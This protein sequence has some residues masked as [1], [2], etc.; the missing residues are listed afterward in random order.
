MLISLDWIKNYLPEL[1]KSAEEIEEALTLIGFEVEGIERRGLVPLQH[2]VVGE[3]L[4]KAQH[5]NADRLS[6]CKVNVGTGTPAQIVCG[7][8]NFKVGDRVPVALPGAELPGGFVIKKTK[9]RDVDSEGMM[10]SARELGMGEDH[11]GLLILEQRPEIGTPVN[12]VFPEADTVFDVEVTPNRPDCLSHVGMARELA[13]FFGLERVR[14]VIRTAEASLSVSEGE[15]LVDAVEIEDAATC[16]YY[17]AYSIRGV[18]IA[19][20]PDWLK[21]RLETIGLRPIN[22]VV[23]VTNFVLHEMGQ[24]LHAFDAGKIRGRRIIVRAAREGEKITTL[25][26]KA[27][28][29]QPQHCVIADAERAMVIAGVMGSVDAE[30]D[31]ATTDVVLEAAWF[32]AP[33]IRKTSRGLI[34]STDSSYRF[35]RGIDPTGVDVAA[36]RAVDLILELAGGTLCKRVFHE[37]SCAIEPT[38]INVSPDFIRERCGFGPDDAGVKRCLEALELEVSEQGSGSWQAKVPAFRQDL[39]RPIDLVEEFLRIHGTVKIPECAVEN[40]AMLRSHAREYTF[41]RE[42]TAYFRSRGFSEVY[43]YTLVSADSLKRPGDADDP[44]PSLRLHNPISADGTHL[45]PSLIPGMV[46]V[47]RN[48]RSDGDASGCYFEW[49]RVY[50]EVGG[51]LVEC[52]GVGLAVLDQPDRKNW[53]ARQG[54]D[55][56]TVK[57][58]VADVLRLAGVTLPDAQFRLLNGCV[59]GQNGHFAVGGDLRK[60]PCRVELGMLDLKY[61]Q[62]ADINGRVYAASIAILPQILEKAPKAVRY[63]SFSHFPPSYKDLALVV[64]AATSAAE[65]QR[66]LADAAKA[67]SGA[68]IQ[69]ESV[70]LF[71][72]YQGKGLEDG[73]KSLA[74]SLTFRA[75]NE[76]LTDA[77][78]NQAFET[79]QQT[80]EKRTPFRVRR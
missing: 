1:R 71:D 8:R 68:D 57:G 54:V 77:R 7:A 49:G 79:I 36:R 31:N 21:Q 37:G 75:Q 51:Q 44:H 59:Y 41:R 62:R 72:V 40:R 66:S 15:A 14:P 55:F 48:N 61:T 32:H 16:K 64:D 6:L 5:P 34:L 38:V 65:V 10:C 52:I 33:L 56:F 9:L 50:A 30:V 74:F 53:L 76:T 69:V 20:S 35:E 18:K 26:E 2:V 4:E 80:I 73:Q 25:D 13:A 45:R 27:R 42:V 46:E 58:M 11:S 19:E 63:A 22:N 24:P 29:L 17:S 12:E 43:N 70:R 23:D 78:V 3:V 39:T 67:V 47:L 28:V 60:S